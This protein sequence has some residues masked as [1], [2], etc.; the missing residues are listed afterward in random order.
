MMT[1][2]SGGVTKPAYG[3]DGKMIKRLLQAF[4][5]RKLMQAVR[6]RRGRRRP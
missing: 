6:N 3:Y 5:L 4:A 1:P 2:V